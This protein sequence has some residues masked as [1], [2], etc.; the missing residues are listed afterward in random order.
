MEA[1]ALLARWSG[2]NGAMADEE[3]NRA[4][5]LWQADYCRISGAPVIERVCAGLAR[6]I[7]RSTVT[8]RRVLDWPGEPREDALPL[9]LQGPFHALVR[10]GRA[11]DLAP[12]YTGKTID[13]DLID[14]ALRKTIAAHDVEIA[15]WLDGPP[16]T[17]EAGRS[18]VLMSGLL[19]LAER[20]G[21][22]FELLEI[23]SSAG[24]NL[25]IDLYSFDLGGV[26]IG[27]TDSPIL[28]APEWRGP[29]PPSSPVAIKTVRGVDITP[30]DL[31]DD[32]QAERLMA[33][34]W[35]DQP[36][37]VARLTGAIAMARANPPHL[38]KGDAADW[39]EARLAEPQPAG[40]TRVLMHSVVWQYIAPE[41]QRRIEAAMMAA[42]ARA[43][44]DRPLGW[45]TYEADRTLNRHSLI[46]RSWPGN[47]VAKRYAT[48]H[49]HGAWIA[50]AEA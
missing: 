43:T 27:P 40:V 26:R 34:V 3:T 44:A 24:L 45:M 11:P 37:R 25:M 17:N 41:G 48:A 6:V 4:S 10:A 16:Q 28:L 42:G 49:P 21:L 39:A 5:L 18:G 33:Y 38:E 32:A 23:G 35:A 12:V 1:R 14:A 9:R 31:T 36:A 8:G 50:W 22:P 47:G 46:V 20:F 7:D 15:G 13:P 30:I 19:V 29:P 2:S